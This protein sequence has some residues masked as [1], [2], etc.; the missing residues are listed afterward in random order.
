MLGADDE[1][2]GKYLE[3]HQRNMQKWIESREIKVSTDVTVWVGAKRRGLRGDV[4]E[5]EFREGGC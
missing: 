1:M 5:G 3:E 4:E 2:G